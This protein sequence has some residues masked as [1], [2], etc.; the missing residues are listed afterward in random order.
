M[1]DRGA[2]EEIGFMFEHRYELVG[3]QALGPLWCL[4]G[5]RTSSTTSSSI[6]IVPCPPPSFSFSLSSSSSSLP[7]SF[8]TSA[9]SCVGVWSLEGDHY[10]VERSDLLQCP[11]LG[12][13]AALCR[14]P[15]LFEL[16][17]YHPLQPSSSLS[18]SF[19]LIL[20]LP[21]THTHPS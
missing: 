12:F 15:P 2:V 20:S 8:S 11:P 3:Q 6:F 19:I 13:Q 10:E 1:V 7:F 18:L 5:Y 21:P 4:L 17:W 14:L 9:R 16:Q